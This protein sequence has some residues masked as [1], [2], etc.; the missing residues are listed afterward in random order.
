MNFKKLVALLLSAVFVFS[1]SAAFAAAP[2]TAQ[3]IQLSSGHDEDCPSDLYTATENGTTFNVY[4]FNSEKDWPANS[5]NYALND[6]FLPDE[7]PHLDE[8]VKEKIYRIM[9]AGYGED[10]L[11]IIANYEVP[12]YHTAW[13]NAYAAKPGSYAVT[14]F[15]QLSGKNFSITEDPDAYAGGVQDASSNVYAALHDVY[16]TLMHWYI[17]NNEEDV[18]KFEE[19]VENEHLFFLFMDAVCNAV[20]WGMPDA[21]FISVWYDSSYTQHPHH[22]TQVAIWRVLYESGVD[23]NHKSQALGMIPG[24]IVAQLVDFANGKGPYA[25]VKVP[26]RTATAD[27]MRDYRDRLFESG[28]V[29]LRADGSP[30]GANGTVYFY[31]QADGT[32]KSEKLHFDRS[33]AYAVPY[34][35]SFVS[36]GSMEEELVEF[37]LGEEFTITAT[38]LSDQAVGKISVSVDM[39]WPSEVYQYVRAS[40]QNLP[41]SDPARSTQDMAGCYFN[42][43]PMELLLTAKVAQKPEKEDVPKTGDDTPVAA[44][45]ILL[46]VSLSGLAIVKKSW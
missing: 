5:L 32:F 1:A 24:S 17:G 12:E 15:P 22:A 29:L 41:V 46:V 16:M 39:K 8:S 21:E 4:C 36:G 35:F 30:V 42:D 45:M 10:N 20:D 13:I 33:K 9:Y 25:H 3:K 31:E 11:G 37:E 38:S 27:T 14:K 7:L 40:Q 43:V 28:K 34:H 6:M 44:M 19:F 23:G 18:Q 26:P 2:G